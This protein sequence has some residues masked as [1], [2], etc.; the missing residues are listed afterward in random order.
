MKNAPMRVGVIIPP[1]AHYKPV[2][3]SHEKATAEF[4]QLNKDIY[5]GVKKSKNI[6]KKKT[7]LSVKILA[8]IGAICAGIYGVTKLIRR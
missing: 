4:N 1:D 8:G 7:P 6:N 3:Y 5:D 2:L